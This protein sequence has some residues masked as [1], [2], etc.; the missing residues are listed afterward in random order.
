MYLR[1]I[2]IFRSLKYARISSAQVQ[3]DVLVE[4]VAGGVAASLAV[5]EVL[6]GPLGH[7]DERVSLAQD[8]VLERGQEASF[9]LEPERHLG[10]QHEVGVLAGERRTGGDEAGVRAPSA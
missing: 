6:P 8:P 10:H 5:E 3:A 1:L 7:D 9:A 4:D 2:G